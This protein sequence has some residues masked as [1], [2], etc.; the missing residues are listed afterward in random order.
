MLKKVLLIT[1]YLSILSAKS[2]DVSD[3][4]MV[5]IY[6][7][8]SYDTTEV[9]LH[10][11]QANESQNKRLEFPLFSKK[12]FSNIGEDVLF[13]KPLNPK[14]VSAM[15][16]SAVAQNPH[17]NIAGESIQNRIK[18][19]NFIKLVKSYEY[20]KRTDYIFIGEI[21]T[22]ATQYEIDLKLI[23]VSTQK[24]VSSKAFNLPFA[25]MVDL[26]FKINSAIYPLMN[27]LTDPFVGWAFLRVDSTSR[28]KVR[29]DD[30][31]IRP[32]KTMVGSSMNNTSDADYQPYKTSLIGAGAL[33]VYGKVLNQ[34]LPSDYKL[35][36]RD[37]IGEDKGFQNFLAGNYRL[38]AYLKNNE[39]PFEVDFTIR[40]GDLNEIHMSL[41]Y[42][43]P[44]KDTDG[45]GI[46]DN[47][48][49][50]P[51]VAGV[52]SDEP[53]MNG[54]PPPPPPKLFGNM[55]FINVWDGVGFELIQIGENADT[56]VLYGEK[57][58]NEIELDSE[59]YKYRINKDKT[60]F[61]IIDLPLGKY[62]R[63]SWAVTEER[64]P[65]KHYLNLFTETDTLNL[66]KAEMTINTKIKDNLITTGREVII[67]FD[68]FTPGE[69]DE[70]LLFWE[71]VSSA[72]TKASIAGELHIV[73][74]PTT[75]SGS[76]FLERD[77]YQRAEISVEEGTKKSYHIADLTRKIEENKKKKGRR[78]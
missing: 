24:I 66:D 38:R 78:W 14:V 50:C 19:D 22:V 61:T 13:G 23:D 35:I 18:S 28:E 21:N 69:D 54:C 29:W 42:T 63:N 44:P 31:Y 27:S 6:H 59:P 40:P 45:D 52:E 72:Y 11:G 4:P 43:P 48:D 25:S 34:Y 17:I 7:F 15:V 39:P 37:D 5:Y 60:S 32:L 76:L 77:G 47:E 75:Y 53:D 16:T 41:P 55:V 67:Y 65:G 36:V 62:V 73:G 58:S 71:N 20:P 9:L 8:V 57:K 1:A 30:I 3:P 51:D 68:P 46:P 64:F 12:D 2:F 56:L 49:D 10:G 33:Q 74:F 26:R 70:Y